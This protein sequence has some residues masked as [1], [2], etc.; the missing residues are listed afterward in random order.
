MEEAYLH[1]VF[2]IRTRDQMMVGADKLTELW[3]RPSCMVVTVVVQCFKAQNIFLQGN[4][5]KIFVI[6]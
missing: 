4:D 3:R 1:G 5:I 2:G 6:F